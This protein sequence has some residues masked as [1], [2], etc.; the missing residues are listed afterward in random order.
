MQ[1]IILSKETWVLVSESSTTIQLK[2]NG[3]FPA[4]LH[5][6]AT[7]PNFIPDDSSDVVV[8][9]PIELFDFKYIDKSLWA[10]TNWA[11]SNIVKDI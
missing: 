6:S 11:N 2:T 9:P 3:P 10:Y 4:Y 1:N 8:L 7:P 5:E